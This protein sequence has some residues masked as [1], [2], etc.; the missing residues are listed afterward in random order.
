MLAA[1]STQRDI[2]PSVLHSTADHR[3]VFLKHISASGIT[4]YWSDILDTEK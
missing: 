1:M 3:D 4:R 2:H